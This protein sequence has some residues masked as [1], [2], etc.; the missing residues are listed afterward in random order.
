MKPIAIIIFIVIVQLFPKSGVGSPQSPDYIIYEGDTI[1]LY[2]LILEQYFEK[3][4]KPN[5]GGLFGLKFREGSTFNCWRGYQAIYSIENDSLFLKHIIHCGELY[6]SKAL[7]EE[8]SRARIAEIFGSKV[9]RGKV[10]LDWYSGEFSLPNGDL[11]RWD[12]VFHKSFEK[13]KLIKVKGGRVRNV[14]EVTNYIDVPDHINRR[15]Q[16]TISNVL[17]EELKKYDWKRINDYDCSEKY[18]IT[19]GK[20]GKIGKVSIAEYQ[21]KKEIKDY[22]ER[23]EYSYCV[24]TISKAL[25]NLR[26]DVLRV[27]GK[28]VEEEVYLEI[29]IEEDGKLENWTN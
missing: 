16:D 2:T 4:N 20:N 21:T 5:Q 11:L 13:E 18:L 17:F 19:I 23:G 22:W 26:F 29:W 1:P 3:V 10:F 27:E 25:K 12:G 24:R 15:Y 28:S 9:R 6:D 14:T 7:D 8:G